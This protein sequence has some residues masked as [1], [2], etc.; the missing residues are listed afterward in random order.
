MA[1]PNKRTRLN[2]PLMYAFRSAHEARDGKK[3]AE[4]RDEANERIVQSRRSTARVAITEPVLRQEV[5][6]DLEILMNTVS[7]ESSFD[8]EGFERVR[9]SILNYGFPDIT[10]RTIDELSSSAADVRGEIETV[11]TAFEPRLI[12]GSIQVTRD[13]SVDAA[14]LKVRFIIRA[15]LSCEPLNVPVEFVAD[16]ELDSGKMM[17][18]RL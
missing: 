17:I 7:L 14:E 18:G 5:A 10:H 11:L 6:R 15:D 12:A 4:Q 9:S 8:L 16:V 3:N 1:G 13:A 2:S